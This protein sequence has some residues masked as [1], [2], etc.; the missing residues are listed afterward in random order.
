M[1]TCDQSA[2]ILS[3]ACSVRS[4]V[5]A[6]W[7]V[8]KASSPAT[9]F[10]AIGTNCL[11]ASGDLKPNEDGFMLSVTPQGFDWMVRNRDKAAA[12]F[13]APSANAICFC[14]TTI[15]PASA[16]GFCNAWVAAACDVPACIVSSS[17]E[18]IVCCKKN[19]D[20]STMLA[21]HTAYKTHLSGKDRI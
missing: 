20:C 2:L 19:E 16:V 1:L 13:K 14:M 7:I 5:R 21:D 3:L 11:T 9:A 4:D 15:S 6:I 18:G 10:A 17:T 8:G 12:T